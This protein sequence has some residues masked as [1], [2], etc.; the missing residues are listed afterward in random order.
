MGGTTDTVSVLHVDDDEAFLEL[1]ARFLE[2][3]DER[4]AIET[5]TS[6]AAALDRIEAGGVD[7]VV[8]DYDMP[9]TTGIEF[10][11]AVRERWPD[12]PFVLFTG[13]GSEEVA[14]DAITAGVT[15]YLRKRT[16]RECYALLANRLRNAVERRRS[17]RELAERKRRLETLISNLPGVV[18]RCANEPGWPMEYV[19]GECESLV[20]YPARAIESGRLS[21]GEDIVHPVD[22]ER[23]WEAVQD[24]MAADEPFELTYRI[25][26]GDGTLRWLWERGR[27]VH[28]DAGEIETL[29]GFITDITERK[30]REVA[31]R[32]QRE[33]TEAVLDAFDDVVYVFDTAGNAV[34][35]NDRAPEE[36]GYATEELAGMTPTDVVADAHEDRVVAAVAETLETGRAAVEADLLR[37]DGSTVPYDFRG[38]ALTDENGGI[39]GFCGV[40]RDV[41]DH[42]SHERELEAR[43]ERLDAFA[44]VVS[45]D[46]RNPLNVAQARLSQARAAPDDAEAHLD[47]VA[48]AH[49]RMERLVADLL[50][51]ARSGEAVGEREAV[52]LAEAAETAWSHVGTG[53]ATLT[54]ETDRVVAADPLRLGQLLENLFRNALQHGA[55]DP[56]DLTVR[57]GDHPDG[58]FVAD[59]GVGIPPDEREQALEPGYT[60]DADG[61]G[62]GL[63]IVS[64]VA[65]AH[66]WSV[67]LTGSRDG[68]ARVEFDGVDRPRR[69]EG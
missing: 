68:G 62:L 19:E 69:P 27:P 7:C 44:S 3:E 18:Y 50:T 53:D 29:E 5:T 8:S 21:W 34:W 20:G 4:F 49:D 10:L 61:T 60:T 1:A 59:D 16:G 46:L 63:G 54:V 14:S 30:R 56:A 6:V 55:E 24:A 39:W 13:K 48:G 65:E 31:L 33:F 36:T 26:D 51:M 47:A 66:G 41:S 67:S 58:F 2:R 25:V 57:V 12:L 40:G 35:W 42:R 15:D 43:N 23:L 22:R 28:D 17:Q 52:P 37:A 32:E 11:E 45:H 64:A 9:G 38:R